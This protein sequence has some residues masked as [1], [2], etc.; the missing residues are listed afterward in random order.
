MPKLR[1]HKKL[2]SKYTI[3]ETEA[4]FFLLLFVLVI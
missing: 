3:F 2:I 4:L 1:G